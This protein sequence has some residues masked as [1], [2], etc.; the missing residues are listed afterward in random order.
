MYWHYEKRRAPK[1]APGATRKNYGS[2]WWG[3]QW[4][5]ALADIDYSNRLPRGKTYANKGLAHDLELQ[6]NTITAKVTG[7]QSQPYRVQ[8]TVPAF[9]PDTRERLVRLV[10][11]NPLFLSKLLNRELPPELNE[12]CLAENIHVFPRRW[13]DLRGACSCPDWAVPCKH[14][15]AVLYLV[16]NEIDKNPFVVFDLHGFDL[17]AALQESGY[18]EAAGE[19]VSIPA[20]SQWQQPVTEADPVFTLDEERLTALDFSTLPD[21]RDNLIRLLSEKPVFFPEG[22][23]K[24]ILAAAYKSIASGVE[25][26]AAIGQEGSDAQAHILQNAEKVLLMLDAGEGSFLGCSLLDA[27]DERLTDFNSAAELAAFLE[28]LP[29]AQVV[30]SATEP[31]RCTWHINSRKCWPA[32]ALTCRKLSPSR[33][34]KVK[35]G[36]PFLFVLC[37]L[38]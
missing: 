37:P 36:S 20:L 31:A 35:S 8:I 24:K 25:K 19:S 33:S 14:M 26:A 30:Q 13:D 23:L 12:A 32:R 27:R 6:G 21:C 5:Q 9:D 18:T 16:A 38:C 17:V 34:E 2:T 22:D 1:A 7:T 28:A 29:H 11:E 3:K 4:L 10:T 15:A